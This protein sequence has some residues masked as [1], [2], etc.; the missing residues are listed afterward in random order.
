[1]DDIGT[2]LDFHELKAMTVEV[3]ASLD[4]AF[5]NEV[6]P[7][8]EINPS[9]ENIAKWIYESLKKKVESKQCN[10]TSVTVWENE[11]ASATYYE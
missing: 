4:H 1:L 3:A 9:S 10:M 6:F 7:F 8:T 2:A 11:T 5:L